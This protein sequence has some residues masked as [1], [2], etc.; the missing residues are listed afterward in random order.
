MTFNPVLFKIAEAELFHVCPL[1]G[2][3]STNAI[4]VNADTVRDMYVAYVE[5][6]TD[7]SEEILII[8]IRER[9]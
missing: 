4:I 9:K 6:G 8:E 2:A 1:C 7:V 5:D 3:V